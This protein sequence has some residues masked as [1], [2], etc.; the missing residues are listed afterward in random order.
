MG[1]ELRE[2]NSGILQEIVEMREV[3]AKLNNCAW[4]PS[5]RT[6]SGVELPAAIAGVVGIE[7]LAASAGGATPLLF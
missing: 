2:G 4:A 3:A 7:K 1:L 6:R 5:L